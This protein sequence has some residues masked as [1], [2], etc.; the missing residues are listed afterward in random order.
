MSQ[1]KYPRSLELQQNILHALRQGPL[2]SSGIGRLVG[3]SAQ[4]ARY[5]IGLLVE[6]G[7]IEFHE[8]AL[9]GGKEAIFWR[10]A[11]K[12]RVPE[13]AWPANLQLHAAKPVPPG[14]LTRW[15]GGNPYER[16]AA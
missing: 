16:V 9:H 13:F 10:L 12:P 4:L 11:E 2:P 14:M 1:M 3:I 6:R 7:L 8:R 5:H 15:V